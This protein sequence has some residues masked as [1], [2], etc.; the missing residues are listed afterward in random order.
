M[1]AAIAAGSLL[2]CSPSLSGTSRTLGAVNYETAYAASRRVMSQYFS[3][4]P[5]GPETGVL[6][7][8]PAQAKAGPS[9]T[10]GL[11][12]TDRRKVATLRL[13]RQGEIVIANLHVE[14]QGQRKDSFRQ[15]RHDDQ[16][17]SSVPNQTPAQEEA[18]TTPEQ[19]DVWRSV[20]RD[21]KLERQI[22]N[23]IH[24]ALNPPPAKPPAEP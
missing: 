8:R 17:Y 10:M 7:S 20:G 6:Q 16:A 5:G 1:T 22:L 14:V 24:Q 21:Q 12:S 23:E 13:S 9:G 15:L 19:N 3:V 18:A 4:L 2:G 11:S